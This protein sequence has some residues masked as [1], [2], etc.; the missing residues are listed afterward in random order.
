MHS[1]PGLLACLPRGMQQ[2]HHPACRGLGNSKEASWE[3]SLLSASPASVGPQPYHILN[4][5]LKET[6]AISL[7]CP[8]S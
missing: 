5:C 3:I 7:L 2:L 6:G 8:G 1:T 4:G